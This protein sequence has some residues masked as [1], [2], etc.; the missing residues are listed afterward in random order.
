LIFRLQGTWLLLLSILQCCKEKTVSTNDD[1]IDYLEKKPFWKI[2]FAGGRDYLIL[3]QSNFSELHKMESIPETKLCQG[4]IG[5][6]VSRIL[7]I[8]F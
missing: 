8:L 3:C 4:N 5:S 1:T 2:L 6:N 7:S